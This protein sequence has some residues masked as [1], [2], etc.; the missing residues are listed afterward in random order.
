VAKAESLKLLAWA[1]VSGLIS[2]LIFEL[3]DCPPPFFLLI[4][5]NA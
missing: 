3:N 1:E 5:K 4:E 2:K